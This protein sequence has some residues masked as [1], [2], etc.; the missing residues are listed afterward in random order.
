MLKLSL[1]ILCT[2]ATIQSKVAR[3]NNPLRLAASLSGF[4]AG[5]GLFRKRSSDNSVASDSL[6][7]SLMNMS[8]EEM[9]ALEF[10]YDMFSK[11]QDLT[12]EQLATVNLTSD[13]GEILD[14]CYMI[15]QKVGMKKRGHNDENFLKRAFDYI[16]SFIWFMRCAY[17]MLLNYF[18]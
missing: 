14:K 5:P 10:C 16:I 3:V 2:L 9:A 12:P 8:H 6:M 11:Y 1:L 13:E 7:N 4:Q 18:M 17:C 15:T